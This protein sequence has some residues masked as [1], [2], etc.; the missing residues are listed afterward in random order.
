MV[1][2]RVLMEDSLGF[3]FLPDQISVL[4]F[5]LY[6][7]QSKSGVAKAPRRLIGHGLIQ[8]LQSNFPKPVVFEEL[9]FKLGRKSIKSAE[10]RNQLIGTHLQAIFEKTKH[11][12]QQKNFSFALGGDHSIAFATISAAASLFEN[13]KVVWIDAHG[14]ANTPQTSPSKNMHG[15]PVAGILGHIKNQPNFEWLKHFI[16]PE[17]IAILGIRALDKGERAF[18]DSQNICYFTTDAIQQNG[19]DVVLTEV[20]KMLRLHEPTAHYLS[21]DVDGVDPRFAPSTG[22]PEPD[23]LMTDEVLKIASWLAAQG[24]LVGMDCVEVNPDISRYG[25][26][27]TL[28]HCTEVMNSVCLQLAKIVRSASSAA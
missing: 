10:Q 17:N 12:L 4:G 18:L 19:I 5:G 8:T 7:G 9:D 2:F 15:M 16:K 3:R 23:G 24:R 11:V 22:T 26:A 6:L 20:S 28:Q 14:D 1:P 21:F 27:P 13:L 25:V